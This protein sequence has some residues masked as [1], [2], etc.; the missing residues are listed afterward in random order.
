MRPLSIFLMIIV[1]LRWDVYAQVSF[2]DPV[3]ISSGSVSGVSALDAGDFN[4]DGLQDVIVMEGGKHADHATFAWFEQKQS[5]EWIR[6]EMVVADNLDEFLGSAKCADLDGDGDVDLVLSSDHHGAG[7]IRVYFFEN[8]G[9]TLAGG[10]WAQ[11]LIA[12]LEGHH[13]NDMR[14]ADMDVDGRMD[15]VIRHKDPNS[16]RILFQNNSGQEW[17]IQTLQTEALGQEGFAIGRLD[18][19]ILP[20]ISING[21]WFEARD[22]RLGKYKLWEI[23]TIF[24]KINPNTKEDIGDINGDGRND[25][26][27]S[28]AEA[29]YNGKDHTLAWYEAPGNAKKRKALW[30]KHVIRSAY[31][32][33]HCVKL[34][35]ID[36]DG[37]LD[38]ISGQPWTPDLITIYFNKMGDFSESTI[39][40]RGKGIYSGA[41]VDMDGDGDIDIVGENMYARKARPWYYENFLIK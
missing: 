20:D 29:Y 30:V 6:H 21:Y 28:P 16:L 22:P 13:A 40:T 26:I 33:A 11:H 19:G 2:G 34:V 17:S 1:F 39:V 37:D 35:D 7:P 24:T 18:K 10:K 32:N 25:I 31:N 14:I 5:G 15:V 41:F 27:I 38:I 4:Q 12:T 23:D 9:G 36:N 3:D 8:P